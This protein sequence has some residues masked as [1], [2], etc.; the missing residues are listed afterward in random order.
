MTDLLTNI[1]SWTFP[2]ISIL[3]TSFVACT[4]LV[5]TQHWHGHLSHDNDL[6]G[7]QKIHDSPVPRVGGLGLLISLG[8]GGLVG[9]VLEGRINTMAMVMLVCALPVF[10]AGLVEDLTKQ[11]SIR[12]RLMASFVSAAL[13]MWLLN[14]RLIDLDT[15]ILDVLIQYPA[16]S[17]LFTCFAVS[18]MTNSVNIIDGLN[19]LAA[20][21]VSLML[22][23]LATIAWMHGDPLVMML[24]LWGIAAMAGFLILNYPFG[25]IFLGDGGAYLAGFWVAECGVLLLVRNPGVSTWAVLLACFYPVWE[26]IFSIYRR[27]VVTHVNSG[28]PDMAHLHHL[29]FRSIQ[30]DHAT[31]TVPSWLRHGLASTVIWC[32]VAC[33]QIVAIN[34]SDNTPILI[35]GTVIFAAG[36]YWIYR[37]MM[38][39]V[40]ADSQPIQVN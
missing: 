33:C 35:L 16:I 22:A 19:G 37:T 4:I 6:E 11:V 25:R 31:S 27:H 20:G 39:Q 10:G 14:A 17:M 26:T 9:F 38:G 12:M 24:C 5:M 34:A 18:G 13:A 2:T 15:P 1:P 29:V 36:Y 8:T 28:L 32:L 30:S 7:A 21:S 23:G 3:V 40:T